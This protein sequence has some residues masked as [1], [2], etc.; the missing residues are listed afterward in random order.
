MC[1]CYG[2]ESGVIIGR[3]R[4]QQCIE[5]T[6]L[7]QSRYFNVSCFWLS[8]GIALGIGMYLNGCYGIV[9]GELVVEFDFIHYYTYH[10]ALHGQV[11]SLIVAFGLCVA[12]SHIVGIG[13]RVII[14]IFSR[15]GKGSGRSIVLVHW[16]VGC[17][18]HCIGLPFQICITYGSPTVV[19]QLI[20][21]R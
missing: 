21:D 2:Q 14:S 9:F 5:I 18:V 8:V 6:A 17:N 11:D 16:I 4:S 10:L 19:A 3:S 7:Q 20:G 1:H 15:Y 12:E 13:Y